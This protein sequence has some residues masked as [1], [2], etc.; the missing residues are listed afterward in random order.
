M[1]VSWAVLA[2][3]APAAHAGSVSYTDDGTT[4][5]LHFTANP[6]E[7]NDMGFSAPTGE[8]Y[9]QVHDTV[10]MTLGA[11]CTFVSGSTTMAL[12]DKADVDE[13][14]VD[15]GDQDDRLSTHPTA[16][17]RFLVKGGDG[18]DR[19]PAGSATSQIEGG[20][21]DDQLSADSSGASGADELSGGPG[22][23]I[24]FYTYRFANQSIS[25]DDVA[26]DGDPGEGDNVHSDIEQVYGGFGDDTMT[27]TA[28]DDDLN[29]G[30]GT[31]TLYGL[32]GDDRL[33]GWIGCKADALFGGP[34]DDTLIANGTGD[35][36]GGPD[37][38]TFQR[39]GESCGGGGLDV[40][41]G[42]GHDQADVN[43]GYD[44]DLSYSL[45][46]VADDGWGS[47]QNFHSDL[48]DLTA[49][50]NGGVILIGSA[51]PNVLTGSTGDDLLQGG[52]GA[53]ALIG[54]GGT[55]VADYSDHDGP[56]TLTLN[57][58][59][60]DGSPGEG[61]RIAA[62][63]ASLRGGAGADS[64]TGDAGDNVL[65]GGPG[66]DLLVGGAGLDAVDYFDRVAAVRVDL[67]G[68]P[69]D[70]G[71]PG[72]GD[73]VSPD[74]EG[75]FGGMGDD[76]LIGG[77]AAGFLYGAEGD[78][79]LT[80][81]GGGDG[82]D[83]AEGDDILDSTDGA[84]DADACGDGNDRVWRDA[85]DEVGDDCE[86][87]AIGPRPATPQTPVTPPVQK[88]QTSVVGGT[89]T[90]P[91]RPSVTSSTR[92]VT[93][94]DHAAPVVRVA[95][96]KSARLATLLAR[97][98]DVDVRCDEACR[99]EGR[100]IARSATARTLRRHGVSATTTLARGTLATSAAS[101]SRR[102]RLRS[103]TIGRSALKHLKSA[104]LELVLTVTDRAGNHRTVRRQL[105]L[106]ALDAN[107]LTAPGTRP[108]GGRSQAL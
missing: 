65:D 78:D 93:P 97:G 106:A 29:G 108:R 91:A 12:C 59:A 67:A 49:R 33:D 90:R 72:E 92:P 24:V 9:F 48:E 104:S 10:P 22:H 68:S 6:G 55:D 58:A 94:I 30:E 62:D 83:G 70:D 4:K 1:L 74:I 54:G 37:D 25:L 107:R 96:G 103:T 60:D 19:L 35:L 64:L 11:G 51:G 100:V 52:G 32:G 18:D 5:V 53:D 42:A 23:D 46:D 82:L 85:V 43:G 31:D 69:G 21:G 84:K 88:P 39:G 66:A 2:V 71:E 99:V 36:D 41:G 38:D 98:L 20:A 102:L 7:I 45:D 77:P 27:G 26:N 89:A 34:G 81:P 14:D 75:A 17:V 79:V 40:H 63:I 87:V 44:D 50:D 86:T 16:N 13:I 57:G 3:I 76:T 73:T 47:T 80:D 61:D 28:G 15:L 8:T 105:S 56:V 95:V 101:G